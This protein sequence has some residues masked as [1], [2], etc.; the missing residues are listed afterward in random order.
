MYCSKCGAIIPDNSDRCINCGAERYSFTGNGQFEA[1]METKVS[2]QP[3]NSQFYQSK[4]TVSDK[5]LWLLAVIPNVAYFLFVFVIP[6]LLFSSYMALAAKTSNDFPYFVK[7]LIGISTAF[8]LNTLF[9][10]LDCTELRR[11]GY[12]ANK[13]M[14]MGLIFV[15][16]YLFVRAKNTTNN[17][18]P[19]ILWC[20]LNGFMIVYDFMVS[21]LIPIIVSNY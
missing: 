6:P 18:V 7:M 5:F 2:S 3:V 9:V 15:P 4:Q 12:D 21:V 1:T 17:K 11:H 13:W 10:C 19:G 8:G 14:W 20:C 16:V